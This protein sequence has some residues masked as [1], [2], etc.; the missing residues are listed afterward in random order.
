EVAYTYQVSPDRLVLR[1]ESASA[2][3]ASS[4]AD[5]QTASLPPLAHQ[6]LAT[7]SDALRRAYQ[8][9]DLNEFVYLRD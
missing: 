8:G 3:V 7:A 9:S 6:A 2:G 1:G 5:Q 4:A